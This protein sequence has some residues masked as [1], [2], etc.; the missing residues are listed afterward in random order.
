MNQLL[1]LSDDFSVS[2]EMIVW[3]LSFILLMS[4]ITVTDFVVIP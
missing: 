3:F 2:L 4:C 1:G